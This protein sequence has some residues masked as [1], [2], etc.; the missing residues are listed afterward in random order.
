MDKNSVGIKSRV[1]AKLVVNKAL[2]ATS[3]DIRPPIALR[4]STTQPAAMAGGLR[5]ARKQPVPRSTL[6]LLQNPY[7]AEENHA[8]RLL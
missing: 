8:L 1:I 5:C 7:D 3:G 2:A 4:K 6:I